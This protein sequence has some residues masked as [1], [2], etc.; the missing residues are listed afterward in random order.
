MALPGQGRV[1]LRL[2][3]GE[4]GGACPPPRRGEGDPL[5]YAKTNARATRMKLPTMGSKNQKMRR[6]I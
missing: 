1:D 4:A 5:G 3:P 2:G 6:A